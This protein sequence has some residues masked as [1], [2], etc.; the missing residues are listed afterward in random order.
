MP[1]TT[2]YQAVTQRLEI[3]D[4]D[5]VADETLLPALA[6]SALVGLLEQMLRLRAFDEK[7]LNLQRQGRL[8]TYGSLRGQEAAQVGLALAL[9]PTDWLIPSIREQGVLELRGL[10]MHNFLRFCKGD[11]WA[12]RMCDLPRVLPPSIPIGSQLVH[13]AGIGLALRLR[14]ESAAA[15]GFCGDGATS[16]GDFHEA[17]NFAAVFRARTLFYVQNNGWAISIPLRQQTCSETLAQKAH[18]YG[19]PGLQV[20][21][22]DVL[23]VYVAAEQALGHVRSGKGPFLLEAETYRVESHTTADDHRRY[24]PAEELEPWLRKDPI[25]RMRRYLERRGLWSAAAESRYLE[26]LAVEVEAEVEK[27]ETLPAPDPV[28]LFDHTFETLPPTLAAQRAE[29]LK[30]LGR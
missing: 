26:A 19:M 15:V 14:E 7:A 25:V 2:V 1:L 23:A 5:G 20:D 22:N 12:N 4:P 30:E 17:L 27:L 6:E 16:E 3:L 11:E 9:R 10:P 13:A 8:G 18:A 29:F 21:G 28:D 24:R